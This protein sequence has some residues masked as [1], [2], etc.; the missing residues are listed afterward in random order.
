MKKF[1]TLILTMVMTL[2]IV[3]ASSIFA[4]AENEY[5]QID[6][7][8]IYTGSI[9]EG[10]HNR[11][12]YQIDVPCTAKVTVE[13]AMNNPNVGLEVGLFD[14]KQVY[15]M[16]CR[17]MGHQASEVFWLERGT[18]YLKVNLAEGDV[19]Y[20]LKA[21]Y[22]DYS[23]D[24]SAE[25]IAFP[26][27]PGTAFDYDTFYAENAV[28]L[29]PNKKIYRVSTAGRA[30]HSYGFDLHYRKQMD[31][32]IKSEEDDY[33]D[34][35]IYKNSFNFQARVYSKEIR[36]SPGQE[37]VT[38]FTFE[39]SCVNYILISN[40]T[41]PYTIELR[42][43]QEE[44]KGWIIE[45]GKTYYYKN[46]IPVKYRQ[47]IDGKWYYFNGAGVLQKNGWIKG[48][49]WF[50]AD[51]NGILKT[52]LQTLDGR[53]YYFNS[54]GAAQKGW[55]TILGKTYY[56]NNS[57]QAVIWRNKI[58]NK[59]Y[60]FNGSGVLQKSGWIRGKYWFYAD[61]SGVL[62]TGWAKMSNKW[63]YFNAKGE[64]LTGWQ[65]IGGKW[66]YLNASGSMRTANLKQGGKT[67]RFNKN[68]VC[69]NP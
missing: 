42:E 45:N 32:V 25:Y 16:E 29:L 27:G 53:K 43:H 7:G 48:S 39:S 1:T 34:V 65:K 13:F 17:P 4:Y 22:E 14:R 46:G 50:Y 35:D 23:N 66:Y 54:F 2:V 5:I 56:F 52:G 10:E 3:C 33:Y 9:V 64:M 15:L 55:Q 63:Y 59:W 47:K 62:K 51:K 6:F 40:M 28:Q 58:D 20:S 36:V 19:E 31:I 44:R 21:S 30:G 61:A 37:S 57:Y 26:C 60:Y 41:G 49:N 67:Y 8:E 24:F 18:Y 12:L 11:D 69:L 38:T 68:G